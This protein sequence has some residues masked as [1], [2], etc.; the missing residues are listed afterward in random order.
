MGL[1]REPK[2]DYGSE[3]RLMTTS[4]FERIFLAFFMCLDCR[5]IVPSI[6]VWKDQNLIILTFPAA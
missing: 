4:G 3:N 5:L 6:D 2:I 1:I